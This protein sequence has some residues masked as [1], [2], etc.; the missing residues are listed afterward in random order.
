VDGDF[1]WDNQGSA[2]AV[3]T[4]GGIVL[5]APASTANI[6]IRKKAAPATPYTITAAVLVLAHD[7]ANWE[8][9]LCFRQSSDG[10]LVVFG[11]T[12]QSSN[13][14][15]AVQKWTS[16]TAWSA[17]YA[18]PGI[19]RVLPL[20][21]VIWLR[22]E[23]DGTD[24]KCWASANGKTWG[25]ALHTVGRTD[26]LTADEVGFFADTQTASKG[27]ELTLLHWSQA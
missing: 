14:Y 25:D 1:S 5:T 9:G 18:T 3:T 24:R 17:N 21:G 27:V 20:G 22:I 7:T 8:A 13:M 19:A 15:L 2:T 6:R 26:F 16:P 23:D 11:P 4:Y 10:K 12:F